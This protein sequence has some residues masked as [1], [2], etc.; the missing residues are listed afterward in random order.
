MSK[1]PARE[2]AWELLCQYNEEPFHR[3]HAVTVEGVM[4]WFAGE[5]GYGDEKDFWGLVG[6]L[7]DLDFERCRRNTA[8]RCRRSSAGWTTTPG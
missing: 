4:R 2:E 8:S 5:L 3:R 7:H 1:M 6:L